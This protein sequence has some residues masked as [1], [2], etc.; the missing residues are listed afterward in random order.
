MDPEHW[1]RVEGLFHGALEHEGPARAVFLD[2]ACTDPDLRR[3]VET[4]LAHSAGCVLD[5]PADSLVAGSQLGPY[6]VEGPI[7]SGGMGTVYKA[8]DT[9]LN[10]AVAIKVSAA[11]F[12]ARFEREAR[13]I[14]AL[15]HPN[16]CTLYDIG[17]NYLVM[18]FV[19]GASL[20]EL[21]RERRLPVEETRQYALQVA[22]AMEAAHAAGIVHRDLKPGNVIVTSSSVVKVL[23]FG[24]A[25]MTQ[26][27]MQRGES[28]STA[29]IAAQS[30]YTREGAVMGTPSYMSP[31]QALGKF[32]DARSDVFAFGVLLY[33]MLTGR[34][35]FGGDSA[36]EV[37]SGI[38]HVEVPPPS[39]SNP[40]A[41]IEL[42]SLV[43]RCLRKDPADRFQSMVEVRRELKA[44]MAGTSA[45]ITVERQPPPIPRRR[46]IREAGL[47]AG[48]LGLTAGFL[49]W[50]SFPAN[51][52]DDGGGAPK[53]TRVTY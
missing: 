23:D 25:K 13:A 3:E 11:R 40:D 5:R 41:G 1:R 34:K 12:S 38:I 20:Q 21:L 52:P 4:L 9:R 51:S 19:E 46:W 24:L 2:G 50:R 17:P 30:A 8:L 16:V 48:V 10:R 49:W 39:A 33:E 44:I 36:L 6:R 35:A 28:E 7:G 37:L 31:E 14:G 47:A 43:A 32:L 26:P 42:D 53:M 18:E 15:N 22:A 45:T 27:P 29:T